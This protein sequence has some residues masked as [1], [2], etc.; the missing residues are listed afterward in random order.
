MLAASTTPSASV[1][2]TIRAS[3]STAY[4]RSPAATRTPSAYAYSTRRPSEA[5]AAVIRS[6]VQVSVDGPAA[7][8]GH[9]GEP[10]VRRTRR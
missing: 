6:P 4:R 3:S 9:P 8:I 10:A 5:I 2:A 7:A 1:T